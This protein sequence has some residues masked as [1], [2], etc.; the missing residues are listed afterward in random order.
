MKSLAT[1]LLLPTALAASSGCKTTLPSNLTPGSSTHNL[2]LSSK[3]VIGKTTERQY[4]L[5]LPASYKPSNDAPTPL[6]VAFH[7]QSQPAWSMEKISELS[8]PD[9]NS[10]R[11]VVYPEAMNVQA[12]GVRFSPRPPF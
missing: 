8:N 1:L 11:I 10:D 4:I 5:H 6:V 7:G 12:P 2:T 3:S 9:F